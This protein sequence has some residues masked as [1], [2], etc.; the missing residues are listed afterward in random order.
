[1]DAY[2]GL[3]SLTEKI[4]GFQRDRSLIRV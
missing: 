1:L 2:L 3:V 4:R